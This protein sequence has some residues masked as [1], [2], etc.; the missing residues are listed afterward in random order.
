MQQDVILHI[1]LMSF[2]TINNK[3]SQIYSKKDIQMKIRILKQVLRI[4]LAGKH[5]KCKKII[6]TAMIPLAIAIFLI[7]YQKKLGYQV[8]FKGQQSSQI[9]RKMASL[10][11]KEF[12]PAPF[13]FPAILQCMLSLYR[14][15]DSKLLSHKSEQFD[16]S[17]GGKCI[18]DWISLK[19]DFVSNNSNIIVALLPGLN[20]TAQASYIE[21]LAVVCLKRGFRVVV[22]AP[23]FNHMEFH[24]P[25]D[26]YIDCNKDF[27]EMFTYVKMK[28]KGSKIIPIGH[29]YGANSIVNYLAFNQNDPDI[30]A[31]IGLANPLNIELSSNKILGSFAD[32]VLMYGFLKR[33]KNNKPAIQMIQEKFGI[34]YDAVMSTKS[35]LQFENSFT[36]KMFGY[37]DLQ[38]YQYSTSSVRKLKDLTCP[39]LMINSKDDPF[40]AEK[41]LPMDIHNENENIIFILTQKGGH[42]GWTSGLFKLKRWNLDVVVDFIEAVRATSCLTNLA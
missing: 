33:I 26:G 40:V 25:E 5:S 36:V 42:L 8:L 21:D 9:I 18:I 11:S 12:C 3:H 15:E 23:R 41:A 10:A 31:G 2:S 17:C 39:F 37:K 28:N 29:S 38:E 32:H 20:S 24:V 27:H 22:L 13:F 1:L 16:F 30:L 34:D 14:C 4:L 35:L 6:A 7:Q 19:K